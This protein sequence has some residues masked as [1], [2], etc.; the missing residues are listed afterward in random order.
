MSTPPLISAAELHALLAQPQAPVL[1]DCSFAL[2]DPQAGALQY[3]QAHIPGAHY[4][5]LEADL[6]G[7]KTDAQGRFAGRHPL[8]DPH[9]LTQCLRGLGLHRQQRLVAY[10]RQGGLFAARLWWLAR[11]LGHAPVQVLDGGFEAWVAAGGTVQAGQEPQP[12]TGDFEASASLQATLSAT[13]LL[14]TLDTQTLLDA[15]APE[16]FSGQVEP[17]D[18]QAGHIPGALNHFYQHNLG[19]DGHFLSPAELRQR[20]SAV[21]GQRDPAAVVHQCGS[22][23]SACHNLLAMAH[24][25]LPA[26]PLY[27]GSWSEWCSD[28]SRP[29]ARS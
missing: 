6:S 28:P 19:A 22:G 9:Q 1:V 2:T 14:A 27:P 24:A 8:P 5:H 10:D 4:L 20:F 12:Q 26:G 16:R 17:L 7:P 3:A 18:P 11:W 21:L 25:G 29:V 13:E 23:V 15:R